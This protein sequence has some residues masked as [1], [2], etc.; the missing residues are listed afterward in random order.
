MP[1]TVLGSYSREQTNSQKLEITEE[2]KKNQQATKVIKSR[3]QIEM[4]AQK[5]GSRCLMGCRWDSTLGVGQGRPPGQS[6]GD[7]EEH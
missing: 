7:Q 6:L 2:T 3:H 5:E 1:D 4:G